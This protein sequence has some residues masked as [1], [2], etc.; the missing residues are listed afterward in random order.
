MSNE[1]SGAK[2][3]CVDN[4]NAEPTRP[5]LR[6]ST[7]APVTSFSDLIF[8]ISGTMPASVSADTNVQETTGHFGGKRKFTP[9]RDDCNVDASVEQRSDSEVER[10]HTAGVVNES[11]VGITE[12]VSKH[13]GF[14]GILKQR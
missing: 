1:E 8:S 9:N 3:R 4:I 6:P 12:F 2:R 10:K 5:N 14:S 11:D 7:G 13:D